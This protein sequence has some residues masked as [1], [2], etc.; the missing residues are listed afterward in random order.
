MTRLRAHRGWVAL[1]ALVLVTAGALAWS[2]S[3]ERAGRLDPRASDRSGSK[4]VAQLLRGQGVEVV[5]AETTAAVTAT[6]RPDD[7]LLVAEPE[8]L[9]PE[10]LKAVGA[11]DADL[12]LVAA[13][14]TALTEL[15]PW[16]EQSGTTEG[17]RSA[18]CE[19]PSA[20]RAGRAALDG[21]AY[22][23][24]ATP[25]DTRDYRCYPDGAGAAL[26]ART[27]IEGRVTILL[28]SPQ[29]LLNSGL[30]DQGNAALALGLLGENARLVWYLPSPTDVPAGAR[31]SLSDLLPDGL[32][33]GVAQLLVAVLLLALWRGRRLGPVVEE[34]LPVVVPAA[35]AVEGRARL[36]RR[37][38]ARDRAAEA[39]RTASRDRLVRALSL[40]RA[41][42]PNAVVDATA[43]AARRPPPEVGTLLY[44]AAPDDD[45][46]LTA[47]AGALDALEKEVR[48]T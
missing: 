45:A 29:P 34:P 4:A 37:G 20:Q 18:R 13:T 3:G 21:L 28:G 31:R 9:A 2:A 14:G 8:L 36:Y 46:A 39:L 24:L 7:T 19:L 6:V 10:Q 35:E 27:G 30:D 32:R 38:R 15:A 44:G 25:D 26:V 23:V 42:A 16:A 41:A 5:L 40:P 22:D 1:V 48:R 11:L 47:L 33:F 43:R 12:V 17:T